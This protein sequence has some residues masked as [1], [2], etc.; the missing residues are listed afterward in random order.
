MNFASIFMNSN[1]VIKVPSGGPNIIRIGTCLTLIGL[2]GIATVYNFG[3][4]NNQKI[5]IYENSKIQV[6][7]KLRVRQA[8][9]WVPKY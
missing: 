4:S 1:K 6:N 2:Y 5:N 9:D 8:P 7:K 3:D